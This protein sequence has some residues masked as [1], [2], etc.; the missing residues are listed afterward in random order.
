[1][2]KILITQIVFSLISVNYNLNSKYY[3]KEYFD[4]GTL[5]NE[6]WM[7]GDSRIKYWYTYYDDGNVKSQGKYENN[8]KN[9]YWYYYNAQNYKLVEGYYK[10]G[11]KNGWWTF[12]NK[13]GSYE[14]IQFLNNEKEGLVLYYKKNKKTPFKADRY[15]RD[16]FLG[17][18]TSLWQFK[19][20]NPDLKC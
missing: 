15:K 19:R 17:S 3:V 5:K 11:M 18:W 2:I 12:I 14:K 7:K 4:N 16:K 9:D 10:I 1:M 8:I 6:G 20:D 13:D